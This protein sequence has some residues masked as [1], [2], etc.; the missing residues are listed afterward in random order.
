MGKS[1]VD[2]LV[3]FSAE[4]LLHWQLLLVCD[5]NAGAALLA[6]FMGFDTRLVELFWQ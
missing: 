3:L 5:T 4:V 2:L 1:V 6:L